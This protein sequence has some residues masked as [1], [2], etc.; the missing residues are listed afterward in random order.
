MAPRA[1]SFRVK[2]RNGYDD[3]V[4]FCQTNN[5]SLAEFGALS[6]MALGL[7]C[8]DFFLAFTE[9]DPTEVFSLLV[10]ALVLAGGLGLVLAL[11]LQYFYMISALGGGNAALVAFNDLIANAL[12]A[13]RVFLCWSR[14][15]FYDFQ[16]EALD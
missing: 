7:V 15:I 16:V 1:G 6:T 3:F 9:E 4:T 12:C 2:R 8:F 10:L 5:I 11:D 13:L 14:Y